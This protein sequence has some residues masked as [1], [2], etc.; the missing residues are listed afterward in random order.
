MRARYV[1]ERYE[2]AAR[3]A[4]W[5]IIGPPEIRDVD[6]HARYFTPWKVVP[7]AE[8]MRMG[9]LPPELQPH[10]AKPPTMDPTEAFLV[11]LFLRRYV[12]YCARHRRF[13]DAGSG[14]TAQQG[15]G[16]P[17]AQHSVNAAPARLPGDLEKENLE[18]CRSGA[19][20]ARRF[21]PGPWVQLIQ[22]VEYSSTPS[23]RRTSRGSWRS[24][25]TRPTPAGNL[26]GQD[27]E[28]RLFAVR[29]G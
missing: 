7:H 12:T 27:Q 8:M 24:G 22:N 10:L 19:T 13:S 23:P 5:E 16:Q 3:Y 15:A 25:P 26:F 1:A 11:G 6:P 4:E 2:I 9:A 21:T 14:A 18:H 28:P 17:L 29:C 20:R